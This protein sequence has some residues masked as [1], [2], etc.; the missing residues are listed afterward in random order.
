MLLHNV[1]LKTVSGGRALADRIDN[2]TKRRLI[3]V[4]K[5]YLHGHEHMLN[6]TEFDRMVAIHHFD[7]TVELLL[8][9]AITKLGVALKRPLYVPFPRLWDTI[10]G[11]VSL[12]KKT[13]MFRLHNFRSNVQHW[14]VSPFSTEIVNR[15][16]I[17]VSDFIREVMKEIFE[18]NFD[19]LF[20]SSLVKDETLRK[21]LTIAEKTFE[22]KNY[23]KCMRY[24]DAAFTIALRRQE[25]EFGV[26]ASSILPE[27]D[28]E[29]LEEAVS[30]LVLGIDYIKYEKYKRFSTRTEYDY[31]EQNIKYPKSLLEAYG[32]ESEVLDEKEKFFTRENALFNLNF[33]LDC[34]LRWHM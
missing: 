19:E 14:G 20:I 5:L 30:M 18:V 1:M 31:S 10:N 17:Y 3:Y 29:E 26:H 34:I 12:P 27:V 33:V 21:I 16:D 15:F 24:T 25:E 7:N 32:A 13:E 28:V 6:E 4:K 11:E 9:C 23:E 2:V 8:K 22:K